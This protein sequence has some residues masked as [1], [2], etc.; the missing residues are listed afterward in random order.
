MELSEHRAHATDVI[1]PGG[2]IRDDEVIKAADEAEI[3][4]VFTG[5][6]AL[7]ADAAGTAGVPPALARATSRKF[8]PPVLFAPE[9]RV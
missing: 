6:A 1:Q 2:S 8:G 3:A 5:D 9:L 7:P 4:M